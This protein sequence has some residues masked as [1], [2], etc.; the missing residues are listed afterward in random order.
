MNKQIEALKMAIA[1]METLTIDTGIKTWNEKHRK[2]A[3]NACKEAL[4][5]QEIG[6]A[7]IRQM[8]N[9]IEYYQ[10]RVEEL[11]S[12]KQEYDINEM[13]DKITPENL[14]EPVAWME[15]Y[16]SCK[17]NGDERL[18]HSDKVFRL[19]QVLASQLDEWQ[20]LSDD[21]IFQI[22]P[23]IEQIKPQYGMMLSNEWNILDFARAIEQAHGIGV[24]DA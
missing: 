16:Q 13:I 3:L 17:V 7:E 4:E 19:V 1:F 18:C 8:L 20:S 12:Q 15:E 24:K 2:E 5:S 6:D 10:K 9:D 11:E 21:E 22:V 14:Q 23:T